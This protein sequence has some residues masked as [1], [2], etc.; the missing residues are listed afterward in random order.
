MKNADEQKLVIGALKLFS[1]AKDT[2]LPVRNLGVQSADY[3]AA[4]SYRQSSLKKEGV[5]YTNTMVGPQREKAC[6]AMDPLEFWAGWLRKQG[7]T[8]S[9]NTNNVCI[10]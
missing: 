3:A 9:I 1:N 5:L 7:Y 10:S 8:S 2:A 6:Y 4:S